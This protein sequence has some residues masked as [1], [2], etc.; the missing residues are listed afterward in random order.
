[1][2][3]NKKDIETKMEVTTSSFIKDEKQ[4]TFGHFFH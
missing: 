4:S 3:L 1:M 2:N